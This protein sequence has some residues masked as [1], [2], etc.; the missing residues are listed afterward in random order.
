MRQVELDGASPHGFHTFLAPTISPFS[1]RTLTRYWQAHQHAPGHFLMIFWRIAS[2]G[3]RSSERASTKNAAKAIARRRAAVCA[4]FAPCPIQPVPPPKPP[5]PNSSGGT[6]AGNVVADCH[7]VI[8]S[9][10]TLDGFPASGDAQLSRKRA[11]AVVPGDWPRVTGGRAGHGA[12]RTF[13]S[14]ARR[15]FGSPAPNI[16][17]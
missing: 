15:T 1:S 3:L 5:P 17:R 11:G 12:R 2:Q 13:G 9:R 10:V 4:A 16:R 8:R 14:P 7:T 6:E